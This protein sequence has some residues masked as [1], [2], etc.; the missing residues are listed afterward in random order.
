GNAHQLTQYFVKRTGVAGASS[1]WQVYYRLNGN[2]LPEPRNDA[3]PVGLVF[4]A[5]GR[6]TVPVAPVPMTVAGIGEAN[7]PA[8]PLVFSIDY[9]GSTQFGGD[10]TYS[11][12]QNG[13]STGE[14]ASMSIAGDGTIVA[15]YTNGQTQA[16]G[17]L[18]LAD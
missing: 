17:S 10:F 1:N 6:L 18:V 8:R 13:Y 7:S 12:T 9:G 15:S 2:P 16:L 3:N 4:D 11:F 5:G 14:Y